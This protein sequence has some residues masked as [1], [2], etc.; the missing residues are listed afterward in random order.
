MN[1]SGSNIVFSTLLPD[2]KILV[3]FKMKAFADEKFL[4]AQML[5]DKAENLGKGKNAM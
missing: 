1:Y 2:H 5:V 4:A 3:Y